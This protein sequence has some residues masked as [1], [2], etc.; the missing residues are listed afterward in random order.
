MH[1]KLKH[2]TYFAIFIIYIYHIKAYIY[3]Y[4]FIYIRTL[5]TPSGIFLEMRLKFSVTF[6]KRPNDD[7]RTVLSTTGIIV[8]SSGR[9]RLGLFVLAP[10]IVS[11]SWRNPIK[12]QID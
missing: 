7:Q 1:N 8:G 4:M 2:I 6:G 3:I 11:S 5:Y 12:R 10:Q 9:Q